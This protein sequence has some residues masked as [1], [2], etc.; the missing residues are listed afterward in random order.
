MRAQPTPW[1]DIL[2]L[3]EMPSVLGRFYSSAGPP[4]MV[5]AQAPIPDSGQFDLY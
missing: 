4:Q 5:T 2:D 3:W 1:N